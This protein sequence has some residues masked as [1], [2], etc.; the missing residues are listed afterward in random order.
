VAVAVGVYMLNSVGATSSFKE[1]SFGIISFRDSHIS[2]TQSS[3]TNCSATSLTDSSQG[4]SSVYGGAFAVLHSPQVSNFVFG[5]LQPPMPGTELKSTGSNVTVLISNSNFSRCS[6]LSSA[7]SVV[8][9]EANGGGGA[10]YAKSVAMTN[11]SLI[12][13]NFI[14]GT[15]NV[16]SGASGLSSFSYGGALAVEAS[17]ATFVAITRSSFATCGAGGANISNLAVRGGAVYVSRALSATVV[18]TNFTNCSVTDTASGDVVS[19]GAAVCAVL[20]TR[21][22]SINQCVFDAS[23]SQ[24]KSGT[25]AGL[26]VIAR[27]SSSSRVD[28]SHSV[29]TASAVMIS[30]QCASDDGDRYVDG[31]C[32]GP[33]LLLRNSA[34]HQVVSQAPTEFNAAGSVLMSLRN[35]ASVSF[36]G[37]RMH[38]AI[39]EFSSFK[40]QPDR[41]SSKG[42]QYSCKPC[43]TFQVSLSTTKVLLEQLDNATNVDRC[44]PISDELPIRSCPFAIHTCTTFVRVSQGFWT[45]FSQSGKLE[46]AQRCPR[47]Y[48]KCRDTIDGACP[49]PPLLSIDRTPDA[50]CYGNRTGKLCGGCAP[51]FTQSMNDRI[52]ISNEMCAKN[53]WWVW[54]LSVLGYAAFSLFIVV[55]CEKRNS[56]AF[57]CL[58]FYFQMSSFAVS[59]DESTGSPAILEEYAQM[60]SIAQLYEGACYSP[61]TGAY[62]ATVFK[63]FGPGLVFL[64]AVVWTWV[65][66]RSQFRLQQRSIY[67]SSSYSG[68]I[69]VTLLYVFSSVANVVFTLAEC[70]SY[71]DNTDAVVFIDGTVSCRDAKWNVV[72]FFAALLFL[73]P[74][75]FT[76]ALRLK[77]L[78]NSARDAV[79][80]KFTEPAFYWGAVTLSFRLLISATQF[81]RVDFPNLLAFV[82]SFLSTGA[83][84]LLVNLRPYVDERAFWVDLVCYICLIA[85]FGLQGFAANRDYLAVS[86]SSD[87]ENFFS[88]VSSLSTVV[89]SDTP[90][91]A[92]CAASSP[93]ILH[94]C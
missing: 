20:L 48:C 53:L 44:F 30:V 69:A 42:T 86:Q 74:A 80:G 14:N 45:K 17:D 75:M 88:S 57:S 73:V 43:Q 22:F 81:L 16:N 67:I 9:G 24:D 11:F 36:T 34:L 82:R 90:L 27:N 78:P 59:T 23:G 85:Q 58:L 93:H 15:V 29:F 65:I 68:S 47:G 28:V 52:C 1:F 19:G 26:L 41:M 50:L 8:P 76:A 51:S 54:T 18:Q 4:P 84:I 63:L 10:V 46:A 49:L 56:G 61:S 7:S 12:Q 5:L 72:M 92:V 64:F 89:R 35:P 87:Q 21:D 40:E 25:S 70:S 33:H 77:K 37:T 94:P 3:V 71:R 83:V 38:C 32:V 2:M 6:A 62:H 79:C 39:D 31:F 60:R 66:Q 13:S 55:S 91:F